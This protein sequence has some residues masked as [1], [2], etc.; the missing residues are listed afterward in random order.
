MVRVN[1]IRQN[2]STHRGDHRRLF[3]EIS[4]APEPDISY[5]KVQWII[6]PFKEKDTIIIAKTSED[7]EYDNIY[8]EKDEPVFYL[9]L[10]EEDY[11]KLPYKYY[12][13][14]ARVK[15]DDGN[16]STTHAGVI[17][18]KDSTPIILE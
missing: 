15:D 10:N 7:D 16:I 6:T 4:D 18:I 12:Y 11:D 13:H 1:K 3:F 5:L 14:E 8:F 17:R 9:D 2:F